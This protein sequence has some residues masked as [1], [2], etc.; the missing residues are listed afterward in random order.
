VQGIHERD[1]R[2]VQGGVAIKLLQMLT[3]ILAE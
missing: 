1:E 2:P 3:Y